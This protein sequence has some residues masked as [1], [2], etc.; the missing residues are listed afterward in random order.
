MKYFFLSAAL[1]YAGTPALAQQDATTDPLDA[2][3]EPPAYLPWSEAD[4][5]LDGQLNTTEAAQALPQLII[6]DLNN[7]GLVNRAEVEDALPAIQWDEP[8][9]NG[10]RVVDEADY[11]AIISALEERDRPARR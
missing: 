3:P 2:Q 5:D 11:Q 1:A 6:L 9:Q 8:E 10:D 4:L 7:D